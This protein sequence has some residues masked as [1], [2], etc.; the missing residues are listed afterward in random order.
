M[1]LFASTQIKPTLINY[2]VCI[3]KT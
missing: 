1:C 3:V 2:F